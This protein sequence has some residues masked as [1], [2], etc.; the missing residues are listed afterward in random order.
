MLANSH[1]ISMTTACRKEE[2]EGK[3]DLDPVLVPKTLVGTTSQVTHRSIPQHPPIGYSADSSWQDS[4]PHYYSR[5]PCYFKPRCN[6][7][8]LSNLAT[9]VQLSCPRWCATRKGPGSPTAATQLGV[10]PPRA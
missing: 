3:T 6:S 10:S 9:A 5:P 7:Q 4:K 1:S 2:W 8:T